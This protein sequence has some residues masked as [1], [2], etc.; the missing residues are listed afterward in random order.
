MPSHFVV[1]W[2]KDLR[3]EDTPH[4]A[5]LK[6]THLAPRIEKGLCPSLVI[7]SR[8]SDGITRLARASSGLAAWGL[9]LIDVT[10]LLGLGE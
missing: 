6:V 10:L 2:A 5:H 1:Q 7:L 4:L 3:V 9:S 8:C